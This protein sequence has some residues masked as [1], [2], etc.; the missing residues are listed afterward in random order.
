M[1]S[2][3]RLEAFLARAR[4]W[5]EEGLDRALPPGGETPGSLH[6][7]MRYAVFGGGKRLRPALVLGACEALGGRGEDAL[8]AAVAFEM[9]HTYSLVHDDLPSMDDDD[10]R[11]GRPTCHKVFGEALALLAGDALLTQ[12]FQV[13][14]SWPPGGERAL[15]TIRILSSVAGSLGMVGGQVLDLEGEGKEADL[16]SVRA[17]HE[18]KTAAMIA[19]SLMAGGTAAGAPREVV[20]LLERAGKALGLAFQIQDDVLDETADAGTLGKTPGKDRRSGKR[21]WPAAVG[22]EKSRARAAGLVEEGLALLGEAGIRKGPL[23]ELALY[24]VRRKK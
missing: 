1:D 16:E 4:A 12:A 17:I 6:E 14:S 21:T 13:L 15:E 19:G 23:P 18:R 10:L 3:E 2:P 8:A 24:M 22:L 9:I 20:E 5:V 11:R 7:A